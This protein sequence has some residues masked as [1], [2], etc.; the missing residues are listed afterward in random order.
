M[1]ILVHKNNVKKI[2]NILQDLILNDAFS[3]IYYKLLNIKFKEG[4][5]IC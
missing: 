3:Y 2:I 5:K 4:N 1:T